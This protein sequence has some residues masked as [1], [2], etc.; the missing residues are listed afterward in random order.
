VP[1]TLQTFAVLGVGAALGA[2]RG[3]AATLLYLLVGA[4][5]LPVYAEGTAGAAR[6]LEPTGG[7]LAGMVVAAVLV[8]WLAQRRAADRRVRTSV[9]AM[10]AG[11]VVVLGVGTAWLAVALNVG[12]GQAV[13]LG[14]TPFLAV[15]ALKVAA[16]AAA[17]PAAWR[18]VQRLRH[19]D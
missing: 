14:I 8:G 3:G 12:L 13:A 6:L 9:L 10:V 16:A 7:Y 18:G 2:W 5:G 17:L 4:L 11:D 15:E 19:H 1:L